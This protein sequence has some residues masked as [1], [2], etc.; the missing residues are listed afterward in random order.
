MAV[1]R[2]SRRESWNEEEFFRPQRCIREFV[3]ESCAPAAPVSGE[4]PQAC[5]KSRSNRSNPTP[6]SIRTMPAIPGG[7]IMS[8]D[9]KRG[10]PRKNIRLQGLILDTDGAIVTRCLMVNVS[11]S[12]AKIAVKK[13]SALPNTFNLGL[14]KN[15]VR[16]QCGGLWCRQDHRGSLR[17]VGPVVRERGHSWM[18]EAWLKWGDERLKQNFE[19]H[20]PYRRIASA[21]RAR[22]GN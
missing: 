19:I 13:P 4:S 12:G 5:S 17:P 8:A 22:I 9:D 2:R 3:W 16:R 11:A 15:G 10:A 18:N 1:T 7:C 6:C 21:S 20:R 14:S